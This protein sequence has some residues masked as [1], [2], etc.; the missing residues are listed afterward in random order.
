MADEEKVRNE[1]EQT[2]K[3]DYGEVQIASEVVSTI[4]GLAATE[5][6][7]IADMS[8]GI[9]SGV[10][11]LLGRKDLSKGVKVT[12][13][14]KETTIDIFVVTKYGVR[15]PEIA[16]DIQKKVKE[17]VENMT[18]LKVTAVNI[19]VQGVKIPEEEV[20]ANKVEA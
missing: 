13:G 10:V 5:A 11:Q 2:V 20:E 4:A 1:E 17:A 18:G 12:V 15:I 14:E 16:L 7:G 9:T 8:G 6:E 3:T 19:H